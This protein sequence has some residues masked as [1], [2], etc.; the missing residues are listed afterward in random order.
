[1][2]LESIKAGVTMSRWF[3]AEARR[4]Y[5]LMGET[6]EARDQRRYVE[7]IGRRGGEVTARDLTH[8]LREF[9]NDPDGAERQA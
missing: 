4:V 2:D 5:A 6:A 1:M 7:W 3:G 8:G 9:R